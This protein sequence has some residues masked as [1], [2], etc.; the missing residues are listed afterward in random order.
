MQL[1]RRVFPSL[2]EFCAERGIRLTPMDLR[3]G[4][5]DQQSRQGSTIDICLREVER[6]RPYFLCL[7]GNNI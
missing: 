4:I 6:A 3:W 7:L 5:T 1:I 2:H